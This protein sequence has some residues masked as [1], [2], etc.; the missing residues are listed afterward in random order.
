MILCG[1]DREAANI[2]CDWKYKLHRTYKNNGRISGIARARQQKPRSM[3]TIDQWQKTYD[4]F[5]S[6]AY[7][8]SEIFI[9]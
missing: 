7:K 2:Y 1:I 6:K 4:I 5:E 8:V 3:Y 9:S